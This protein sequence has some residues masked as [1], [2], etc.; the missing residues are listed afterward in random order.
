MAPRR[1][2]A[3][4]ADR[5]LAGA[6][7]SASASL[8][9]AGI[10]GRAFPARLAASSAAGGN[11]RPGNTAAKSPILTHSARRWATAASSIRPAARPGWAGQHAGMQHA[12]GSRSC[13][14]RRETAAQAGRGAA[15]RA[16]RPGTPWTVSPPPPRS[17]RAPA[18]PAARASPAPPGRRPSRSNTP[19]ST[20]RSAGAQF[21]R[22][23]AS[24]SSSARTS[25]QAC[26]TAVP[27]ISIGGWRRSSPRPAP[28]RR[29]R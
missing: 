27:L 14:R 13:T 15:G 28:H 12:G 1:G 25:A 19:S 18:K 29:R 4:S 17:R 22:R 2:A 5:S 10:C 20:V 6:V 16:R 11:V 3:W 8:S 21:S 26:R 24:A 7:N 9:V 23:A